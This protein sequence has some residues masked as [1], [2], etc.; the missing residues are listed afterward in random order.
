MNSLFQ[1]EN[2]AVDTENSQQQHFKLLTDMMSEG[3]AHC[4][5]VYDDHGV[6][7]DYR[8]LSVNPSFEKH[9]GVTPE[10][11]VG[12]TILEIMPDAEKSWIEFYGK[13][14]TTLKPETTTGYN[15]Q[16]KRYYTSTAYSN[17]IGEFMMLFKDITQQVELEKAYEMVTKST[18]LNDDLLENLQDGFKHCR[19]IYDDQNKP[20]DF[21]ILS[22]NEAYSEQ[23]G[24]DKEYICGKTMLEAFPQMDREKLKLFCRTGVTGVPENFIDHCPI[25]GKIFDISSFSPRKDEFIWIVRDITE[26]EKARIKLEEA[27]QKVEKSE[28]LKSAFLANMSHEIRTPLNAILGCSEL[29]E[30]K[31]LTESNQQKCLQ[32]IKNSGDRLLTI[33]SDILDISKFESGQQQLNYS[34]NCLNQIID[35]LKAQFDIIKKDSNIKLTS[36]KTLDNTESCIKTDAARLEQIISNLLEN[37]FKYTDKGEISFGYELKG[38]FIEFFVTDNGRGIAEKDQ[39]LIFERFGQVANKKNKINTGT[40]L[41]IPIA[42]GFVKLFG[43]KMWVESQLNEGATFYFNIPHLPGEHHSEAKEKPTILVAEDEEVNYYLLEMWLSEYCNLLHAYNGSQVLELL[44]KEKVDLVLMDIK[45]P[46]MN[47]VE[48][49][50]EI[51]K[52]NKNIPIIAQSAFVMQSEIENI[53]SSG[54]NEIMTKPIKRQTFQK[55]LS[56]YLPQL[57]F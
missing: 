8:F 37:A 44:E 17:T 27:Y 47:G 50:K 3:L 4:Q 40:G 26:K 32:H 20:C 18:K 25:T 33:I 22:I 19:I 41:G 11:C 29:L 56:E 48:A 30:E 46:Y 14:A 35:A 52:K 7:I 55:V 28:Q 39:Q 15:K 5:V 42:N 36:V 2:F 10:M 23:T 1:L 38:D 16:T 53:L 21:K 9:T 54:C 51:R 12:K 57:K 49:T 6:P 24:I 45:M 31:D 13:V 43:G 34:H